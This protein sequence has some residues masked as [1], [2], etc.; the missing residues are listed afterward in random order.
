MLQRLMMPSA[1]RLAPTNII[2]VLAAAKGFQ[3]R[4]APRAMEISANTRMSHQRG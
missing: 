2:R 4:I 3:M 1:H